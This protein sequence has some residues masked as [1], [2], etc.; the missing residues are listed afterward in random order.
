M[1]V[2]GLA[3]RR[4]PAEV[5]A[6]IAAE[7]GA[8]LLDVPDVAHPVTLVGC[9]PVAE[10]VVAADGHLTRDGTTVDDDP[11]RAVEAFVADAPCDAGAPF[12]LGGATVGYLG[13][14]LGRLVVPRPTPP[15]PRDV[16]RLPLAVLRHHDPVLVYEHG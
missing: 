6:S 8:F 11:L 10:L 2:V 1:S 13:Y 3:L 7:P 9:R 14:E 5:L 15:P 16:G 12:P 4:R